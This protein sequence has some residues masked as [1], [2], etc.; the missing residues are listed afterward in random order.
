ML[1]APLLLASL[2]LHLWSIQVVAF[3][4]F[5]RT[6]AYNLVEFHAT[7]AAVTLALLVVWP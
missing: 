6:D 2:T 1:C 7:M 5:D 3:L 4:A